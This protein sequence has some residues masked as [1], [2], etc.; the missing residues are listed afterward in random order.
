VSASALRWRLAQIVSGPDS[1]K[2]FPLWPGTAYI[3]RGHGAEI[4]VSDSSV[5]RRHAKLMVPLPS[6]ASQVMEVV[7]LGSANGISVGGSEVP[8]ALLNIGERVRL[9]D[10]EVALQVLL[11]HE[12]LD[13]ATAERAK[14]GLVDSR[15]SASVVFLRSPRI[16]PLFEGRP[17]DLPDLPERPKPTRMPWLALMLPALM[18][19]GIFAFTRSP[20]SLVFVLMSP[21]MMLGNYVEARRGSKRDFEML[22]REFREDVE[23]VAAQIRTSLE[24]E[25]IQR[26]VE[27]PSA[28]ACAASARELSPLL[29]TRR[30]DMPGFLQLRLGLGTLASRSSLT[31]PA[32]G[33]STAQAW[34]ELAST[35]KDLSVVPEVPVVVDPLSTGAVGV[36]GVEALRCPRPG[37]SYSRR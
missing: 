2:E 21:M 10:T 1:G 30:H 35:V 31:M 29:W 27:H 23:T 5:S 8:R 37:H 32:F 11:D 24:A 34:T 36:A 14:A 9:G 33:R 20:Y 7:D 18:G 19:M 6:A 3:G 16:A 4:Q 15:D 17:F 28:A 22:M 26:Q 12:G 13:R 25:A